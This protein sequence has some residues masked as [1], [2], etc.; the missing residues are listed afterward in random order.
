MSYLL[1]RYFFSSLN[2]ILPGFL[3]LLGRD[4]DSPEPLF[5]RDAAIEANPGGQYVNFLYVLVV[6]TI[7]LPVSE[8]GS[9]TGAHGMEDLAPE[10]FERLPHLH[11]SIFHSFFQVVQRLSDWIQA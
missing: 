2:E 4:V 11:G 3:E 9:L 6:T 8:Q 10:P 7:L 5:Q 1:D